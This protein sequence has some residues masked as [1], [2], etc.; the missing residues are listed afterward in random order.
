[1]AELG[2]PEKNLRGSYAKGGQLKGGE[3]ERGTESVGV[4]AKFAEKRSK[5]IKKPKRGGGKLEKKGKFRNEKK[6]KRQ[7][8]P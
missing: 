5:K 7:Q 8:K 2:Y 1:M 4:M 6:F 3:N